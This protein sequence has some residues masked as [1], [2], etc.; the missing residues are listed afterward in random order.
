[1]LLANVKDFVDYKFSCP[2][3]AFGIFKHGLPPLE[4]QLKLNNSSTDSEY[5]IFLNTSVDSIL[6]FLSFCTHIL[7]VGAILTSQNH[8]KCK[9][10][11]HFE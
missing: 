7:A 2:D 1:M 9:L 8:P 6:R 5:V 10:N 11:S 4:I 3:Q